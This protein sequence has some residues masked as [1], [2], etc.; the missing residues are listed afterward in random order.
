MKTRNP[1]RR[2]LQGAALAAFVGLLAT[3]S[4]AWAGGAPVSVLDIDFDVDSLSFSGTGAMP[5]GANFSSVQT[6][7]DFTATAGSGNTQANGPFAVVQ[8][9]DQL[10]FENATMDLTFDITLTDV[11]GSANF[12][13]GAASIPLTGVNVQMDDVL[14]IPNCI[15]DTTKP[16]F[17]CGMLLDSSFS[18][19]DSVDVGS[20]N[21]GDDYD[22][23]GASVPIPLGQDADNANGEDAITSLILELAFSPPLSTVTGNGLIT[24]TYNVSALLEGG[25]NPPFGP[26]TLT[27]PATVSTPEPGV[28]ALLGSIA[29]ALAGLRLRRS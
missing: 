1:M 24:Q 6:Q 29:L 7:I 26:F 25:I 2:S 22:S 14:F 28:L 9:G 19:G 20:K 13:G 8:T 10:F 23:I 12:A 15:A 5:L 27:G 18:E 11:D 16:F 17:G 21:E 4:A 3:G